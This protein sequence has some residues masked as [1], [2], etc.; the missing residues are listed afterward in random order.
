VLLRP[1][2]S[3]LYAMPP[4]STSLGEAVRIAEVLAELAA[5]S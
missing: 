2:G 1:L 3:V 4:A 5:G